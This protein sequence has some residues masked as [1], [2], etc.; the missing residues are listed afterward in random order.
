[1]PIHQGSLVTALQYILRLQ[2]EET[3]YGYVLGL[4]YDAVDIAVNSIE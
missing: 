4:F 3:T 1:V 2:A